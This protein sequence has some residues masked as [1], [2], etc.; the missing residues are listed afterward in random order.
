M[1]AT[2]LRYP[3]CLGACEKG[4]NHG[5]LGIS[6]KLDLHGHHGPRFDRVDRRAAIPPQPTAGGLNSFQFSVFGFQHEAVPDDNLGRSVL[7]TE[8]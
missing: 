5:P 6:S 8:N 2:E 7:N 3:F 4:R 1:A